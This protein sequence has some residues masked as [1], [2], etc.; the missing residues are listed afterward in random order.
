[1]NFIINVLFYARKTKTNKNGLVPIYM[2][3][4]IAGQRFETSTK[5]FVEIEKWSVE[6]GK[7]KGNSYEAME[8]NDF[9]KSLRTRAVDIQKKVMFEDKR[10][11]V[12]EFA[13]RWYGVIKNQRM[14]LEIFQYHNDQ[15]KA[16]IGK[17]V[18]L[19]TWKRY[20]TSLAHTR[21]FIFWKFKKYDMVI[22]K[23][24][25]DFITDYEFW[26]K[27]VRNCNHN[28]TMKYLA[29]FKK[30][31]II[32]V[33]N[34]WLPRDP[35]YGYKMVRREVERAYLTWD[36]LQIIASK[37]FVTDRLNQVR[38]TFLF[39]CYTGLAYI[40]VK[41]L[42]TSEITTGIDGHKWIFTHRQKTE[43]ASRI[44]LL[45][46]ALALIEKYQEHPQCVNQMTVL[47]IL[48][49]QKMNAYLKEITDVCGINKPLTFHSARHTFATTVTLSNGI[50]IESVG[51][52]LGHKNLK[53][54][55]HYA[56]ILDLKVSSD[57]Q[58]LRAKFDTATKNPNQK[59]CV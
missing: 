26:L 18:A 15:F 24:C 20:E 54:T 27:S 9:L 23:I 13:N 11:T 53:T 48:S 58:S 52:M 57:M 7:L 10:L 1:M 43:T 29:N 16:L 28:T 19:G 42:K 12:K 4:T 55:Q 40:D 3:V 59:M 30:I 36:E 22:S 34:G 21:A 32:C 33:K 49:N 56:K 25:Y 47:P 5:R 14:L 41:Q 46:P 44:P 37:S 39:C 51:K 50:P 45:P 31:I 35:F 6:A 38:D 8:V 2:R 17:G